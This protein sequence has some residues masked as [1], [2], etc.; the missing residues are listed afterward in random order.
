M[1]RPGIANRAGE[2]GI[3]NSYEKGEKV[4]R[5]SIGSAAVLGTRLAEAGKILGDGEITGH[6]NLLSAADP[7]T[8]NPANHRLVVHQDRGY[9]VV[10]EAHILF[11]LLGIPG[12]VLGIL[13][14]VAPGTEGLVARAGKYHS[15]HAAVVGG[16]PHGK[17]HLL[18]GVRGIGVILLG[19]VQDDPGVKESRYGIALVVPAGTFFEQ[20]FLE[21]N[22]G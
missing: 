3:F 13:L 19:V 4:C 15:H 2:H 20:D 21:G 11:I 6:A 1:G 12:I 7:H 5:P 8:V 9:H 16:L 14:G 22:F 18:H 10:E 17:N